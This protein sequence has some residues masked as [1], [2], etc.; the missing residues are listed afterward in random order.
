[1]LFRSTRVSLP[2]FNGLTTLYMHLSKI[3]KDTRVGQRVAAKT[4]IGY[5]GNTGLSTGPHLHFGVKKNGAYVDFQSLKPSR[6]A[7]VPKK[8]LAGF[9]GAVRELVARLGKVSTVPPPSMP[10]AAVAPSTLPPS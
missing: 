7:G 6:A 9:K 5:S 1:M 2:I 10:P 8:D 3:G 4:V